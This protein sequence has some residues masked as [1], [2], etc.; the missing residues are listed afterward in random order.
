MKQKSSSLSI[1]E[2]TWRFSD[3]VASN[4]DKHVIQSV[5]NY[6]LFQDYV[7]KLSEWFLKDGCLVYDLGCSTGQT[8]QKILEI[9]IST[10]FNIIGIDNSDKMLELADSRIRNIRNNRISVTFKNQDLTKNLKLNRCSLVISIL[11]FPFLSSDDR[12]SILS[13]I[14]DSLDKGGAFICVEKIR[15]SNSV[16]EDLFNQLYFDF[17]LS[18]DLSEE[19]IISK[20]KS[21][22]SS[23]YLY[24]EI[25]I[26]QE[27]QQHGFKQNEVFFKT[28]NFIGYI[29]I[30]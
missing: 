13:K 7:A 10:K 12:N 8:I 17:K 6:L 11:L 4:F 15:S 21:L 3:N 24:D 2:N 9:D 20:A 25:S 18:Q 27:L 16:F 5:P 1:I 30:K 28:L 26:F 23:M 29:A 14:Y 22:R 19:E